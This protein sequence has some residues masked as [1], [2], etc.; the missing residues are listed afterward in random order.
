M[1]PQPNLRILLVGKG[2]REHALAW[3]LSQSPMVEHI[4]VVPGN[5]GTAFGLIKVSNHTA[6][7]AND[8]PNLV[9]L[10]KKL[11]IGLVVA[12][13]DDV[14]VDGI[15]GYF[16]ESGIPCFAPTKEA[17]ELEGSKTFSK[18]FMR[19]HGI[20]TA[21]YQNFSQYQPAKDYIA[22]ISSR[23][24]IKVSGL[25][26]GKGV[27]LPSTKEEAVEALENIM[28]RGSFGSAGSSIVIEE[29][30]E[31][32][33]ISVLTFS[34]GAHTWSFPPGQDHKRI[35]EGD[36]GLN[37]GGMGVYAPTPL[38]TP[39][40]MTDIE[41]RV[42][43]PTFQGLKSEG[44]TFTGMLFTGIMLTS[45]GPKVL[46][47]NTRFGD[48]ETQ[49]M[50]PLLSQ[51]TDLA[52]VL[53]ACTEGRLNQVNISVTPGFACNVVV[54]VQGYP[55]SYFQGDLVE[56]EETP[57]GVLIF[58][59]GTKLIDGEV[60][61]AGGRVFTVSAVRDSL[62]SAVAA[63]YE[64]VK[65]VKFKDMYYRRDIANRVFLALEPFLA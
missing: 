12:G 5:A 4:F 21:N 9:L 7:A 18:D 56:F 54:A 30:L 28:L 20:P 8:F 51:D 6:T 1:I 15:E 33:E 45:S 25:A 40:I 59:A 10:A 26:A 11:H 57:A 35:F 38:V 19:R 63:A 65:S 47:Y 17:A 48:P 53:L 27:I 44:R 14:V 46:E 29:Y 34:D 36:R 61:T 37:T 62:E 13:P 41:E 55:E 58:H 22:A 60:R 3:K 31:G 39:E 24:V 16:R 43:K 50:I 52:E 23:L 32:D 64:G 42:L 49:S 2:G